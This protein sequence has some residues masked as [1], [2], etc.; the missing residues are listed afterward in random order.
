MLLQ[1]VSGAAMNASATRPASARSLQPDLRDPLSRNIMSV[2]R[3]PSRR[4]IRFPPR[5]V[6]GGERSAP[7]S[8]N[9]STIGRD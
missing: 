8:V 1:P 3:I 2:M 6:R 4:R 9:R 7:A 5:T